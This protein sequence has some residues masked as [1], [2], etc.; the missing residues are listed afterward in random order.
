MMTAKEKEDIKIIL[1]YNWYD[2]KRHY[3]C[4]PRKNH[5]F[6][7]LRRLAKSIEYK[8]TR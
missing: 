2:E 1:D 3:Q 5:I 6:I 7:V 8:V 4:A